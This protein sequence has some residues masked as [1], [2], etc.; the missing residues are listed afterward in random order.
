MNLGKRC[1]DENKGAAAARVASKPTRR[2]IQSS[3]ILHH[4]KGRPSLNPLIIALTLIVTVTAALGLGVFLG[5]AAIAAILQAM[6]REP[7]HTSEHA[8]AA[9]EAS[10]GD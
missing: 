9:T 5:Y 3:R 7:Q 8:V 1:D 4:T 6:R 10:S 2:R